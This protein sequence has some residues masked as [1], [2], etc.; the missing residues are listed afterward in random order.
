ECGG[1][2][3]VDD[4]GICG[5]S[6][7]CLSLNELII[8]DHYSIS[9]I[10]PNPFNPITSITYGLPENGNV[11]LMIYDITG[12]QIETLAN[13]FQLAGYHSVNWDASGY[14]S[15]VYLVRMEAG[16]YNETQK[17]VMVK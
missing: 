10:Y 12:R 4:C 9:S 16:E 3:V 14:P 13:G 11:E 6:N 2:A 1:S 5:G 8:P 7:E 17:M 15:G